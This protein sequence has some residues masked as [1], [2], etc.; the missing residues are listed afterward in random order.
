MF[1]DHIVN[2]PHVDQK[3]F[4]MIKA[5]PLPVMLFGAGKAAWHILRYLRSHNIEPQCICDNNPSKHETVYLGLPVYSYANAKEKMTKN[6]GKYQI[7]VS[8]GATHKDAIYTQLAKAH[9]KNPVWYLRGYELCGEKIDFYYV[10]KH[11]DR[12]ENAYL[13]L[14]DDF[15]RNV[16]IN[17]LNAKI[18]GNFAFY[19]EIMSKTQYFDENIVKL[20]PNEVFL[21]V[22]AYTGDA[23]I[24]FIKR[25]NERYDSIIA[26]EPDKKTFTKLCKTVVKTGIDKVEL[27][28]MGAW[29]KHGFLFFH[30]GQEAS[31]CLS[32]VTG[33]I[34]LASSVEVDAI[35]NI[36]NGRRVTYISM[37][38][39]GAESQAILGAEQSIKKWKPKM[40]VS[41]YHKRED[42][43]ALLLL[44][45]SFVSEYKF[46]LRHYT[47]NQTETFLYAI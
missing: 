45:K 32:E 25:T 37:D 30:D 9:E 20:T 33:D 41:V 6:E 46:Y 22:G 12:F 40:A 14:A 5:T 28:N 10:R 35:D 15:S 34:S 11:A 8:V 4:D 43:F 24:E 17:V 42:L 2:V 31:S 29:D 16:F 39:E 19:E 1:I 26:V 18:S 13:S 3:A 38:I 21:D 7:V 47:D 36:L 27:H 44:I 23:V